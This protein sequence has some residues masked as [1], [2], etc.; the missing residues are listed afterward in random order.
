MCVLPRWF[1]FWV[2]G[3]GYECAGD[4]CLVGDWVDEEGGQDEG[5][6]LGD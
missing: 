1:G 6:Y 5:Y 4:C 3:W 2:K